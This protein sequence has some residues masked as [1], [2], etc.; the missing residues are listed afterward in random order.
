[1]T[2]TE[3]WRA[4]LDE[5]EAVARKAVPWPFGPVDSALGIPGPNPGYVWAHVGRQ[6]PARTLR[7]VAADRALLALRPWDLET[8]ELMDTVLRIR[9]TIWSDHP[10]YQ[11]GWAP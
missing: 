6:D 1:M 10:D 7:Q 5:D 3:F 11:P 9:L 4:R 2:P 8:D